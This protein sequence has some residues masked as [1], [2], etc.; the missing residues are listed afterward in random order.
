MHDVEDR[1]LPLYARTSS[2][3]DVLGVHGAAGLT[4][5]KY[6]A[7][8][9]QLHGE[10]EAIEWA[11]IPPGGLSG[12][13]RHTR[14][15]ELYY[16]L[17]GEGEFLVNGEAVYASPGSLLLTG[18]GA[19]HGL[20][21]LG[22]DS[23]DWLVIEVPV[24]DVAAVLRGA[25]LGSAPRPYSAESRGLA[26]TALH[27]LSTS[28][29]IDPSDVFTGPLTVIETI[30]IRGGG[31]QEFG[32]PGAEETLFVLSGS[33]WADSAG[34]RMPLS[35]GTAVTL[36]LGARVRIGADADADADADGLDL[37]HARMRV[38]AGGTA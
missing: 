6:L 12:E 37:F 26:M 5:W 1:A 11:S 7:G 33:G 10:W 13:H 8:R 36:P 23:L 16:V 3:A 38:T 18:R 9:G 4:H 30:H 29:S 20:R 15:E 2:A 21:N 25:R 34:T 27:D 17:A 31:F 22:P 32:V 24:P 28:R 19:V 35:P 14:T